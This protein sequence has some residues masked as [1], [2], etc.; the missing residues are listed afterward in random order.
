MQDVTLASKP[1]HQW[2]RRV[3]VEHEVAPVSLL[4]RMTNIPSGPAPLNLEPV[5]EH[6]LHL[7]VMP[8]GRIRARQNR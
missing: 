8:I 6:S 3:I 1:D 4:Q 5:V 2:L 7:K